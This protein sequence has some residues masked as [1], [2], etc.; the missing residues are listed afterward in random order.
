MSQSGKDAAPLPGGKTVLVEF[1]GGIAR[2]TRNRPA[3]IPCR[4]MSVDGCS[5]SFE[6][7]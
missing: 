7:P 3:K 2:V 5:M 1:E 6:K 4:L